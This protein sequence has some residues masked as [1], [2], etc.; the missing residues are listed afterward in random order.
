MNV[1]LFIDTKN[2]VIKHIT[3]TKTIWIIVVAIV[4][5]GGGIWIWAAKHTSNVD[6]GQSSPAA[7][8]SMANNAGSTATS[9]TSALQGNSDAAIQQDMTSVNAQM[10]GF[11]SDSASMNQS[12]NDQPVSQVQ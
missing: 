2:K 7:T 4:I 12:L 11:A 8:G 9:S 1:P 6:L 10:N 5:I 3:M